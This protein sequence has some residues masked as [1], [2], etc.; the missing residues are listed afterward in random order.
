MLLSP[1]NHDACHGFASNVRVLSK[2]RFR[3][4]DM[5]TVPIATAGCV[6]LY[7]EK[8]FV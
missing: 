1:S 2:Q 5:V 8:M 6:P 4:L 3:K 7:A